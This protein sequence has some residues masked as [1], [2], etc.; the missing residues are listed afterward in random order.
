MAKTFHR[1][2]GRIFRRSMI[3]IVVTDNF[4]LNSFFFGPGD[5]SGWTYALTTLTT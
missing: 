4:I 1:G 3:N 2:I 5:Y